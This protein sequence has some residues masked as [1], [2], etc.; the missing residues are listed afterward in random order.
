LFRKF[1]TQEMRDYY[2]NNLLM[3]LNP[4]ATH[5]ISVM[6]IYNKNEYSSDVAAIIPSQLKTTYKIA[7]RNINKMI[8]EYDNPGTL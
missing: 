6:K 4:K 8:K 7:C 5:I 1:I 3:T 2:K